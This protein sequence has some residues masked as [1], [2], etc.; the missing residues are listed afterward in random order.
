ML[1]SDDNGI[2][3]INK[4]VGNI[5]QHQRANLRNGYVNYVLIVHILFLIYKLSTIEI[6][7]K[8]NLN[9]GI[10]KTLRN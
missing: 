1:W 10:F 8:P 4:T 9:M 5:A 3:D 7:Y 2:V 6:N